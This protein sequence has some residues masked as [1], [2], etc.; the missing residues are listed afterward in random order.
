[1][2]SGKIFIYKIIIFS[3][4][5]YMY[6][7]DYEIARQVMALNSRWLR[8]SRM[9]GGMTE[10]ER[11][12]ERLTNQN[13]MKEQEK[14]QIAEYYQQQMQDDEDEYNDF[15]ADIES[16]K[17]DKEDEVNQEIKDKEDELRQAK[18]DAKVSQEEYDKMMADV[19]KMTDQQLKDIQA[20]Q[21][22]KNYKGCSDEGYDD[23][24]DHED[25]IDEEEQERAEQD[26][27]AEEHATADIE[28]G[29]RAVEKAVMKRMKK[30]P[31]YKNKMTGG[32]FQLIGALV[33]WAVRAGIEAAH[34][35]E[36]AR[37]AQRERERIAR[38]EEEDYQNEMRQAQL[39]EQEDEQNYQAD[40]ADLQEEE[41]NA[42][43]A[44]QQAFETERANF[45]ATL[46]GETQADRAEIMAYLDQQRA[47]FLNNREQLRNQKQ[48]DMARMQKETDDY[49]E[50]K[51]EEKESKLAKM[52]F[53]AE[54]EKREK[55]LKDEELDRRVGENL[56]K[57]QEQRTQDKSVVAK[58]KNAKDCDVTTQSSSKARHDAIQ[59][60]K[61]RMEKEEEDK[62]KGITPENPNGGSRPRK[63]KNKMKGGA[64]YKFYKSFA[65]MSQPEKKAVNARIEELAPKHT[66]TLK[67]LADKYG[68]YYKHNFDDKKNPDLTQS[69]MFDDGF[70]DESKEM[71]R[72]ILTHYIACH[73]FATDGVPYIHEQYAK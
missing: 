54:K 48:A 25:L 29:A 72:D 56:R 70:M 26:E 46:E 12:A 6:S 16:R 19:E 49:E 17:K 21:S 14:A 38:E 39:D 18:E 27:E 1:M 32:F 33:R 43:R 53:E 31:K 58:L 4:Y 45:E 42:D 67:E 2:S 37:Q 22:L 23:D 36:E 50:K 20:F 60:E 57:K 13:A 61:A 7:E 11:Q 10:E 30:H 63:R 28:G 51:N 73:E 52:T 5:N 62:A 65:G 34:H 3:K 59:E 44:E 24:E 8:H 9:V 40:L 47:T 66:R 71:P 55:Q 69:F 41:E 15:K 68:I 64:Y 35:A